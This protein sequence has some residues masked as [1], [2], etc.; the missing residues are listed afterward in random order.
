VARVT[1]LEEILDRRHLADCDV[2]HQYVSEYLNDRFRLLKC[3]LTCQP[4]LCKSRRA[5][6]LILQKQ[7]HFPEQLH[8]VLFHDYGMRRFA[9][10]D[11]AVR[12]R[13]GQLF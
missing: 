6:P 1:A 11:A 12:G 10:F 4:C 5:P 8:A 9:D 2:F 3:K 7:L 13:I